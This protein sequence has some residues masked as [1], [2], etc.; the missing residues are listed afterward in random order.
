M[1]KQTE[2][3]PKSCSYLLLKTLFYFILQCT[4]EP[5]LES[6][7]CKLDKELNNCNFTFIQPRN[8]P[9]KKS[10]YEVCKYKTLGNTRLFSLHIERPSYSDLFFALLYAQQCVDISLFCCTCISQQFKN[11]YKKEIKPSHFSFFYSIFS[12]NILTHLFYKSMLFHQLGKS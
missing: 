12:R 5:Y 4:S 8:R 10:N 9:F 2:N 1:K 7:L 3:I 6:G 11:E